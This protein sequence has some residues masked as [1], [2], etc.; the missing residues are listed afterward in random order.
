LWFGA[1]IGIQVLAQ[2][3]AATQAAGPITGT[4]A[5]LNGMATANGLPT[6]AWFEWGSDTSYGNA[7]GPV[8]VGDG[9]SVVRVSAT[10]AAA[11]YGTTCHYRLVSSN[12]VEVAYGADQ[13][14]ATAGRLVQWGTMT[15]PASTDTNV[16]ARLDGVVSIAAGGQGS[17]ALDGRGKVT[18]WGDPDL[19]KIPADLTDVVAVA[20]GGSYGL[21]LRAEGT[22]R[23]WGRSTV[24]QINVPADLDRVVAIAAGGFHNL[25]LREDGLVVVWGSSTGMR[26]PAGLSNVVALAAGSHSLALKNDGTVVAWGQNNSGQTNVPAD[27]HDVIAVAAGNFHSLALQVDG[28]VRAWGGQRDAP[29]GLTNVVAIA[30]GA[31]H[32]LAM[33]ADGTVVAWGSNQYGQTNVPAALSNVTSIAGGTYHS[34]ALRLRTMEESKPYSATQPAGPVTTTDATLNGMAT[35]NGVSTTAWFEWGTGADFGQTTT[36]GEVGSSAFVT[37]VRA[38]VTGLAPNVTY[39]CRLVVSNQV[40]VTRGAEQRFT[41]GARPSSWGNSWYGLVLPPPDL[42]E[43][44]AVAAGD[45][46]ALALKA[47]GRVVTWGKY[48]G[49][50]TADP[51]PPEATNVI[52]LAGGRG[53]DLALRSDG[54]VVAWGDNTWGQVTVPAGW[55]NVIAISAGDT[56]GLALRSDGSVVGGPSAAPADL[57]NVVAISCGDTHS[58]ALRNDGTVV[59]WGQ[60]RT[61][62][63]RPPAGLSNVVAIAAGYEQNLALK[64]DGTVV[65]WGY[66]GAIQT[67]TPAGLGGV[68][69]IASGDR[70][71]LALQS[72]GSVVAWGFS[73]YGST[74]VPAG[75]QDVVGITSGDEFC[76]ALA[77]NAPP[78]ARRPTITGTMNRDCIVPTPCFDPN[79]DVV[80][81]RVTSLPAVGVLYQ[82][83]PDGRGEAITATDTVVSD[84]L[85]RV[86]FVPAPDEIGVPYAS[87]SVVA[88]D[89]QYDSVPAVVTLNIIPPVELQPEGFTQGA[90]SPFVLGFTGLTNATYSVYASVNLT[91]WGRLGYASQPTPGQFLYQDATATTYPWRFYRICS[92]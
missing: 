15:G 35:P 34:L 54:T 64:A 41:T 39:R 85:G 22:V 59:G 13:I 60:Y 62:S 8:D 38:P 71:Y 56:F 31:S 24:G 76:L 49:G 7:T 55:S 50:T 16:P 29:A 63:P 61:G 46:H 84:P 88:N 65:A 27:L 2:P 25:A 3:F 19:K 79:G 67:N 75:L 68:V 74:T 86:I 81:L 32:S 70:H 20:A 5:M 73:Y 30:A 6:V 36:P 77:P 44:V 53:H 69:A 14:F 57:Q 90:S 58:L 42:G 47:D 82:Y 92:P 48:Y 4:Q 40:A 87:Y 43:V 80:T 11:S 37:R 91:N 17:L 23:A 83:T 18:A 66:D 78:Q 51:A 26:V 45:Y 21:A 72:D 10:V 1:S 89:G 12:V 52:A 28:T 33:K 9:F